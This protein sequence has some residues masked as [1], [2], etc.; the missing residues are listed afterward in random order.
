MERSGAFVSVANG[1]KAAVQARGSAIL[2]GPR[3]V[4]RAS[5]RSEAYEFFTLW[6]AGEANGSSAQPPKYS[7]L[8]DL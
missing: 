8:A 4:L 3:V 7:A 1:G 6:R 2:S 5:E